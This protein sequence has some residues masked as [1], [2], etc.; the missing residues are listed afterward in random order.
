MR[1]LGTIG[2]TQVFQLNALN[3]SGQV[4]GSMT[5]ADEDPNHV[6]PF[7]WNGKLFLIWARLEAT[8]AKQIGSMT[9]KHRMVRP[10][11]KLVLQTAGWG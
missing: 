5:L 10:Q 6:H 3:E 2:G 1:D 8:R 7:L 11:R 9:G 4:V